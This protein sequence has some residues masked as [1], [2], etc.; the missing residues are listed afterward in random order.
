MTPAE[1]LSARKTLGL[2]Q[3]DMAERLHVCERQVRRWEKG[4]TPVSYR[5][6]VAIEAMLREA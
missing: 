6:S 5:T 4:D 3:S 1:A 2:S